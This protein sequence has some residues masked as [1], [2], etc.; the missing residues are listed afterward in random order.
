MAVAA[1][2]PLL[3]ALA[4]RTRLARTLLA[5]LMVPLLLRLLWLLWLLRLLA[6]GQRRLPLC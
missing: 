2:A 5:R 4:L 3:V 1:T 6:F